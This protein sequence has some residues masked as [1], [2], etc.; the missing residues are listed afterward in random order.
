MNLEDSNLKKPKKIGPF[1]RI[2]LGGLIFFLLL[3]PAV[4]NT[5]TTNTGQNL[6]ITVSSTIPYNHC[7]DTI[8]NFDETGVDCGGSM[9]ASCTN[10]CI[11]GIKN[12]DETGVD[13]GGALCPSCGGGGGGGGGGTTILSQAT[14]IG[15]AA[16]RASI[17]VL[18][19]GILASTGTSTVTGDFNITISNLSTGNYHFT[20][21][22]ADSAGRR[23]ASLIVN[24]S[25]TQQGQAIT[26]SN[27]LLSP[28]LDADKREVK[29]GESV[30]FF[31][32]AAPL[33]GI[34]LSMI[35]GSGQESVFHATSTVA[36]TYQ[37]TLNTAAL[38]LG[39]YSVKVKA[40]LGTAQSEYTS[41]LN[42]LVGEKTV[43][44]EPD[45]KCPKKGDLNNDCRVNLID[46]SIAAYWYKRSVSPS[47]ISTEAAQLNGDGLINLVDFSILAYYWTG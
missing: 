21:Y 7:V 13:C 31:G 15:K 35:S 40:A 19:D 17:R 16:P 18:Y 23:S 46:F 34:S 37:F 5:A 39:Q 42:L 12:F 8:Q 27:I 28:T 32:E 1:L 45:S 29:Q 30:T 44:K 41:P 36:G 47:F 9:C 24:L 11:D 26:V 38:T 33:S 3:S 2:F 20:V 6:Y 43:I 14:F 10:H 25:I 4:S 22:Y